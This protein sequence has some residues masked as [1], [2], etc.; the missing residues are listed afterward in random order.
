MEV[1]PDTTGGDLRF[2]VWL[3]PNYF[4]Q[5]IQSNRDVQVAALIGAF[6]RIP[7]L[8]TYGESDFA[9]L[10][11]IKSALTEAGVPIW[12]DE[13][14]EFDPAMAATAIEPFYVPPPSGEIQ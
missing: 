9:I 6:G 11:H 5:M 1:T 12:G 13:N 7:L 10:G 4:N 8:D 2:N 14:A 3:S